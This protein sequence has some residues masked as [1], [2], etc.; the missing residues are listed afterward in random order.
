MIAQ[1]RPRRHR[2]VEVQPGE[3][4]SMNNRFGGVGIALFATMVLSAP[5]LAWD[6][7]GHMEVAAVAWEQMTPQAQARAIALIKLN[8]KFSTWIVQG[9][10]AETANKFSFMHAATWPD[11]IKS[12]SEYRDDGERG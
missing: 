6:G 9:V 4:I 7:F 11:L 10:S 2:G 12:D 1:A 5:A 3:V 8:P